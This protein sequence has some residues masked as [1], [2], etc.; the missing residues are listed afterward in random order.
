MARTFLLLYISLEYMKHPTDSELP[1]ASNTYWQKT[2]DDA[3]TY[4]ISF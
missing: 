2:Y 3:S 4:M 1:I